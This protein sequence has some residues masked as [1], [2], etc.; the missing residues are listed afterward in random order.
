MKWAVSRVVWTGQWS[1]LLLI[2]SLWREQ[3]NSEPSFVLHGSLE[4]QL[5]AINLPNTVRTVPLSHSSQT[6]GWLSL[7]WSE[8]TIRKRK[9]YWVLFTFSSNNIQT[10]DRGSEDRWRQQFTKVPLKWWD[11][12]DINWTVS[13]WRWCV[14]SRKNGQHKDLSD[15]DKGQMVMARQLGQNISKMTDLVVCS[16]YA[17]VSSYWKW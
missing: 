14:G 8:V 7:D 17:V 13:S 16:R 3:P 5:C 12:V 6:V 10:T 9:T 4:V 11:I 2:S 1:C 15:F